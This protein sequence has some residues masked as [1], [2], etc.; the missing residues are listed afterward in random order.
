MKAL[1]I[2]QPWAWAI[3]HAG[4]DIEN[5]SWLTHYRGPLLIHA[6]KRR[7]TRAEMD[8][9]IEYFAKRRVKLPEM[10]KLKYGCIIGRVDL[11]DCVKH[12]R[13][14]WWYPGELGWVLANPRPM[15]PRPLDGRLG[16]FEAD[17]GR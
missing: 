12:S 11:V 17:L 16:L 13:S 8:D 10:D 15:R 4:K 1:A 7:P 6:G 14:R 3:I 5:R 2:R 9:F